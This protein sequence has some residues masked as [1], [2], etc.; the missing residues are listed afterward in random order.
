MEKRDFNSIDINSLIISYLDGSASNDQRLLLEEWISSDTH[1]KSQFISI[2]KSWI[3]SGSEKGKSAYDEKKGWEALNRQIISENALQIRREKPFITFRQ[4][5]IAASWL[6]FFV[7][8]STAMYLK[9]DSYEKPLSNEV[10]YSVPLGSRSDLVLP[11]GS[12]VWLNAGTRLTYNQDFGIETRSLHLSGE[13]FFEVAK[14]PDHPFIVNASELKIVALGTRFNV[15]AY[16]EE[17]DVLTTLEEGKIDVQVMKS[18]GEISSL[19][20]LPNENIIFHKTEETLEK[21]QTETE[22]TE[23][24]EAAKTNVEPLASPVITLVKN[25]NT[26]LFTSWKDEGWIIEEEP[27]GTLAPML[28]RRYNV[29]INFN[30]EHLKKFKFTGTIE[31]ETVE[32]MIMALQLSSP[33]DFEIDKDVITLKIN[34]TMQKRFKQLTE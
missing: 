15:K 30:D 14:D 4:L 19:I 28:E 10:T 9:M 24:A 11:D 29:K 22:K 5:K 2:Y 25:V 17:L 18:S 3:A 27:L 20:V 13:A 8:G 7:L 12:K 16:P 33:I 26:E 23:D 6:I 21:R 31:N 34:P 1:N 32:Q